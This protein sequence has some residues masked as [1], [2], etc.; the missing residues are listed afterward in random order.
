[1][2][3]STLKRGFLLHFAI[4]LFWQLVCFSIA[5]AQVV[6]DGTL[7]NHRGESL[8]GPNFNITADY[9]RVV[10]NNLFH[11]FSQFDLVNG[12]V[13]TFSGPANIQNILSRITGANASSIDGTIQSTINGANL[14]FLNPH[15]VI[16]GAHAQVDVKGSFLVT[17]A[18]YIEL[19]DG[20]RFDTA[21]PG[22][23]DPLLTSATPSAFGFLGPTVAPIS[24]NGCALSVPDQKSFSV[25]GGD[26][27]IV[28]GQLEA[29]GGRINVISLGSAGKVSLAVD[30]LN[31]VVDTSGFSTLGTVSLT[32]SA[33]LGND[34]SSVGG[35]RVVVH[36]EDLSFD[37]SGI[38]ASA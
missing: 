28:N 20:H 14:F 37:N 38:E 29:A 12:D 7:D 36:A 5:H 1:M 30:D 2:K 26:V 6:R 15:G 10:G 16:F 11:S 9:G 21:D 18:H 22:A 17:S 19:S 8:T 27:Q 25:V 13:A 31:A 3:G 23:N 24:F 35:G 33:L 4:I 34:G 32:G